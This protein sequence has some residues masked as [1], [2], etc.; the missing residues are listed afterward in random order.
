MRIVEEG[1]RR[2]NQE[3]AR[4]FVLI[5]SRDRTG[6]TRAVRLVRVQAEIRNAHRDPSGAVQAVRSFKGA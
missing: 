1:D 4:R 5:A 3:T 6:D 2:S